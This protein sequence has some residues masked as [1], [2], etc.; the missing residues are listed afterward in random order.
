[1]HDGPLLQHSTGPAVR[2]DHHEDDAHHLDD[3]ADREQS[4]GWLEHPLGER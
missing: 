4:A 2:D 3:P 1:V